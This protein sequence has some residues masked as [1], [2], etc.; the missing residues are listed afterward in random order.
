MAAVGN[1]VAD[2]LDRCVDEVP[3]THQRVWELTRRPPHGG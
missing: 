3:L 2:A 1:P